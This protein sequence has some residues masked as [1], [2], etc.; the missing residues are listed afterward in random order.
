[1]W[2][3]ICTYTVARRAHTLIPKAELHVHLEGTAPPALIRRLAERNGLPVP[4]GV[5]DG[6]DR[7]AYTDFL[8][9]LKTYDLAASVIRTAED[10]RRLSATWGSSR[11][12][13]WRATPQ[14]GPTRYVI[15]FQMSG[16]EAGFPAGDFAGIQH[17]RRRRPRLLG[18]RR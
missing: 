2:A 3:L 11:R 12:S 14:N 13:A 6:P 16:D 10:Y 7:F 5:F 9:F 15:G 1:V 18:P 4:D 8:D 17:R